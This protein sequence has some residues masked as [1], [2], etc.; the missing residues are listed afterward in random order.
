MA[1]S[2]ITKIQD[3]IWDL[4]K[5]IIRWRDG[6]SCRTC[7]KEGLSG[8][9]WQ[10]GHFIPKSVCGAYLKYDLRNLGIQCYHCN[11]NLGGNGGAFYK[12]LEE[13]FDKEW[14]DGLFIDKSRS[15]RAL[16]HYKRLLPLYQR[17]A[18]NLPDD[19]E[20]L[21]SPCELLEKEFPVL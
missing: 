17:I 12:A 15:T 11:I 6:S 3:D 5:K 1:K 13:K 19:R 4:C 8:S 14:V 18:D 16:E 20:I 21:Y 7:G 10:T 2:E 9:S